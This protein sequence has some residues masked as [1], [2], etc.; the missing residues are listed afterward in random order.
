[1]AVIVSPFETVSVR[2][3]ERVLGHG[4]LG[5][6]ASPGGGLLGGRRLGGRRV[7]VVIAASHEADTRKLPSL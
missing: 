6:A 3:V 7:V 2:W 1:M 5:S 4:N